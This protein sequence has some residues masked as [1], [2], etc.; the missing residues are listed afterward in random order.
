[1]SKPGKNPNDHCRDMILGSPWTFLRD[2]GT[3]K[4]MAH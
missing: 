1:M 2:S 3:L 4:M